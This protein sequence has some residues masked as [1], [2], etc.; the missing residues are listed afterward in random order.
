MIRSI[1]E[2]K[3]RRRQ[4]YDLNTLGRRN[5]ESSILHRSLILILVLV[6]VSTSTRILLEGFLV[7]VNA[8]FAGL[9]EHINF[10]LAA[11]LDR[12]TNQRRRE[13]SPMI[14]R[15]GRCDSTDKAQDNPR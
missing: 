1:L 11:N 13:V 15:D 10:F 12:K 7:I 5:Q 4:T 3:K 8:S 2:M 6:F 9:W 14:N